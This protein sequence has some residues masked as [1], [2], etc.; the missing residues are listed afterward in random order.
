M[1][2]KLEK[3]KP[4]KKKSNLI[5]L[6][7]LFTITF[8]LFG[9]IFYQDAIESI[10]YPSELPSISIDVSSDITD[11]SKNCWLKVSPI[12]SKDSQST[13]ANRPLA[14]RIRKRNSDEGFS[15]ELN[16]RE[17]LLQIRNDDDW[18]LLPSGNNL[19]AIRTKLSFDF[20]N[21]IYE[22]ESNYRLPHSE[23]VDLYINGQ[24]KGIFL[25]S[26][27]IDR[28]MLDLKTEDINNPEQNDVIIKT[29]G[30][31]GDFF[32]TPNFPESNIEQ[33]Y[34]NS[35]SNTYRIVDLIDFVLNSTEEEFY[36][37]NTGIFSL[38]DKNSVIDN[39]LF[40]L[41]SGNNIIEGFSYFLIYNHERAEN[42]AGFSFLPWHFEQSFGYS[43]YGKIPQSLWLNKEDNKIDPVVWSNLYN[44]LLFPEE[45]SSINSNFLSDVKNRWNNIFNNYW[46]I[47]EL[48]DYFDNIYSTVQNSLIQTGYENS[49]YE[50]F[51][52]SIHNWIE[53]RLPLLN[54]ILTREDTIT[55]GQ[56]E[57]LYQEDD[58]VFGF[59]DSAARRYYYKSSVI[60]S[61]DKIHNVNITIREDFLTNI[62]DRKFDGDW[63]TNHIWMASNVSIDG[64][65]INNVGIRIKANLGSLNTPKN[66]FKLKFSEGELYHFNDRE[67]YG[68]YHYYPENIDRRFL[69]IKNLNLRAGPGDSSLLNEPIG[70]EIFKITGNPYLRISWGRLYITLTDESGKVLKP[71]E[72]KGLYWITEQLD[73]TYLRTRFKN[74]NGN[75]Y[76]T[77]GATALLNS[78]WVTENPDD[79]KILG[80]YS[81]PYRR[82]YELKTNTEV[83]DYTDLRDFLYFINFDWENIE[84]ITDLS[85][86]AKY[87]ASSIYQG[88]WDDYIIIAHNYYLYSD[89]NIG[90]VMIPWDIENNLNAFS[91]FLGNFSDAPLLNGYQDHFNWNNW[92]FWFGNWSWDPKTRP[93]W[94]N[95][96]KDPVFVNYYLNEIEKILNETQYL[97][98]KVDQ[99]S[100]LINESLLLPFNVTSPRDASAY[101][102]PYTIQIDNNSYINEKSRVINFLIDRQ[103]FVEEELKKPVE[104]L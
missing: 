78:W 93:L 103:K 51:K 16:Q 85:I 88:S 56:F 5:T 28:G 44:R 66:S 91:S 24:F 31:D 63:E 89:P 62:I 75:L 65:S 47:E 9:V 94:D 46:K 97:L 43:K 99:W 21:L 11:I 104:E 17:N 90:F 71:Q 101:Q 73:K 100:N 70:H 80:T 67:G 13:W 6:L 39:F 61:K 83:D 35:I 45:S 50:E 57:S 69:G 54:E 18:I 86:I 2:T 12:S 42:S 82:T 68:E 48:I 52:D 14:G 72:Y 41:F 29:M 1:E 3:L 15:I 76:K 23:L 32:E 20:Y 64:Y 19:D 102:T 33:L 8:S 98:E 30:W 37:E 92:G 7:V 26:E 81:P 79:L 53:K 36:D 10:V 60:F 95:A 49:F 96:A 74:P 58:N 25:L 22:P 34:P 4:S 38:L 59:S 40:G 55:F 27:R 87:F 77:T 84:Y